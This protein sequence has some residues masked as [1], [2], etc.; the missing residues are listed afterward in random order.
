MRKRVFAAQL[1]CASWVV[2]AP[3]SFAQTR[4]LAELADYQGPD[5]LAKLI[6]GARKEGSLSLYTSRVAEDMTP[7]VEAFTKR[8]TVEV[9]VWRGS[10]RAVL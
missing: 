8:Y 2:A 5:R 1:A 4:T 7:V 3:E 10:N 9:Q 6:E